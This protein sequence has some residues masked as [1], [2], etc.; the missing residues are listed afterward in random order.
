M[1]TARWEAFSILPLKNDSAVTAVFL[2][3]QF[4]AVFICWRHAY[5]LLLHVRIYGSNSILAE[6]E[7]NE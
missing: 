2:A 6:Q 1:S 7:K 5:N 4:T 3:V